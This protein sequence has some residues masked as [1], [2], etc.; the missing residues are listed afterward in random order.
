MS[1]IFTSGRIRRGGFFRYIFD[2]S[3]VLAPAFP[4]VQDLNSSMDPLDLRGILMALL[5]ARC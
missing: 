3:H 2:H 4:D 5:S 1:S